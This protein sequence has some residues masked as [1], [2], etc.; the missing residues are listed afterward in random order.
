MATS[1]IWQRFSSASASALQNVQEGSGSYRSARNASVKGRFWMI[2]DAVTIVGAAAL[3]TVF[4]FHAGPVADARG[5]WHG[6]LIHGRSMWILLALLCE[7]A[8]V[9][10][11]TS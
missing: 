6:T 3:A 9:L 1:D 2:L 4:R 8:A 5:F 7:F 10:I 11:M